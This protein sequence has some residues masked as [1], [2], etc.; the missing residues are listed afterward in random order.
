MSLLLILLLHCSVALVS[1]SSPVKPGSSQTSDFKSN[2]QDAQSLV[3]KMLKNI[4]AAQ[5][6]CVKQHFTNDP[7]SL[8]Y[9]RETLAIPPAPKLAPISETHTMEMNLGRISEG[10][11]LHQHL[12]Q[13]VKVKVDCAGELKVLLAEISELNTHISKVQ[14]LAGIPVSNPQL[15]SGSVLTALGKDNYTL[16]VGVHLLLEQLRA[17]AQDT[18]R[19]LREIQH[20]P[21]RF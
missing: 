21:L 20:L 10:L 15:D 5:K 6:S 18:V 3:S 17:F 11:Q 16:N 9:I 14:S 19:S 12:L 8:E 7:F 13:E 4:P 1:F 2:V